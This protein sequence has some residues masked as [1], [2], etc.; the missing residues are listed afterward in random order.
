MKL[1]WTHYIK[2][3]GNIRQEKHKGINLRACADHWLPEE[4]K[5]TLPKTI[6]CVGNHGSIWIL[7]KAN[8]SLDWRD[9][10]WKELKRA[11]SGADS[12][13]IKVHFPIGERESPSCN[14]LILPHLSGANPMASLLFDTKRKGWKF[15]EEIEE[16]LAKCL[17]S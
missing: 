11:L 17:Q 4:I 9:F 7:K 6:I 1:Y 2:C 10:F 15:R 5:R 8:V 14:L 3:F 12:E 16:F 13:P